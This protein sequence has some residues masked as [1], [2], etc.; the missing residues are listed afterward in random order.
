MGRG[1]APAPPGLE[2]PGRGLARWVSFRGMGLG[3]QAPAPDRH[4]GLKAP[5]R[6]TVMRR[7]RR[8]PRRSAQIGI[9]RRLR[10]PAKCVAVR[11]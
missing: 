9:G 11:A 5:P 6:P 7:C 4:D 8:R 10:T 3:V 1:V 2:L